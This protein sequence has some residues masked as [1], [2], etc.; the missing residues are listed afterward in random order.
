[1][2]NGFWADDE[3]FS[4]EWPDTC[5]ICLSTDS[6]F[7]AEE[8]PPCYTFECSKCGHSFEWV[9]SSEV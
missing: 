8:N 6:L 3:E 1:M 5:S 4:I 9:K 2:G 7:K